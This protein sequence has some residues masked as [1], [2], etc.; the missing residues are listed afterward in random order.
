MDK[1]GHF[2]AKF[3]AFWA[4]D[5]S[6]FILFHLGKEFFKA[7]HTKRRPPSEEAT[8]AADG[9]FG[10]TSVFACHM[11]CDASPGSRAQRKQEELYRLEAYLS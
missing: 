3:W 10:Q 5:W 2:F 9:G 7:A 1:N 8:W 4:W 11:G 6:W